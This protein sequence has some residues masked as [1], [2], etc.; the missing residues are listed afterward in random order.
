MGCFVRYDMPSKGFDG[1]FEPFLEFVALQVEDNI[2]RYQ[3][4]EADE[5]RQT[6]AQAQTEADKEHGQQQDDRKEIG[7]DGGLVALP[8]GHSDIDF[9][10]EGEVFAFGSRYGE[11]FF[12]LFAHAAGALGVTGGAGALCQYLDFQLIVGD[13]SDD[14]LVGDG[15]CV[16]HAAKIRFLRFVAIKPVFLQVDF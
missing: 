7:Q 15:F 6:F 11:D 1:I 13:F 12:G 3:R 5:G 16:F 10:V 2:I 8:N 4:D 9:L 14:A